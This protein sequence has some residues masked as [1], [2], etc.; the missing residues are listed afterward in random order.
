MYS[1]PCAGCKFLR[2]KCTSSC[3]FAPYFPPDQPQRFAHVHKLFGASNLSKLLL[4][5][6]EPQREDAVKTFVYEAD[7]RVNDP[8]YGCVGAVSILQQRIDQLQVP[9]ASAPPPAAAAVS[10]PRPCCARRDRRNTAVVPH[11]GRGLSR[12]CDD[13]ANPYSRLPMPWGGMGSAVGVGHIP[14]LAA[15]EA[16]SM[17]MTTFPGSQG[18]YSASSSSHLSA[19]SLLPPDLP[20]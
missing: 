20:P 8:V 5:I 2:R 12:P 6:P 10:M 4:D 14:G 16:T 1:G 9:A 7:A 15:V 18:T 3:L 11:P 13:A 17:D 19:L